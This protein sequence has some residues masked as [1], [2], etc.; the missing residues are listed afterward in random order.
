MTIDKINLHSHSNYGN[1]GILD[2]NNVEIDLNLEELNQIK[3]GF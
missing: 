2:I 3:Q 1:N